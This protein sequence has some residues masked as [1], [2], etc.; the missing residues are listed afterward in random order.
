MKRRSSTR[1]LATA[2]V[3]GRCECERGQSDR[4]VGRYSVKSR[5][6]D[7]ECDDHKKR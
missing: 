1:K 6:T 2:C 5:R 3:A 4:L 7:N